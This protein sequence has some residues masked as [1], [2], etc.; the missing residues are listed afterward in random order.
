MP[1][2]YRLHPEIQW[3]QK[4]QLL[5][6]GI[7]EYLLSI[8]CKSHI[9]YTPSDRR[10]GR[11]PALK[12][13]GLVE[14][15]KVTKE[16]SMS[17]HLL[18][19]KL[20][21]LMRMKRVYSIVTS[22]R[23]NTPSGR[24]QLIDLKFALHIPPRQLHTLPHKLFR[25]AK[26]KERA[27]WGGQYTQEEWDLRH[28]VGNSL[29]SAHTLIEC[30]QRE[31]MR[32]AQHSLLV[33]PQLHPHYVSGLIEGNGYIRT[34][35]KLTQLP[36]V[37]ITMERGAELVLISV[38][39]FFH[40]LKPSCSLGES[41]TEYR[42]ARR[43]LLTRLCHHFVSFPILFKEETSLLFLKRCAFKGIS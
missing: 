23:H 37:A 17:P 34:P 39:A 35:S 43:E 4:N 22:G 30:A 25:C 41:S 27:V 9:K 32:F 15:G 11:A 21:D 16:L 3:S 12:V 19:G 36:Q 40:D 8:N 5:L 1:I 42:L 28:G 24:M 20:Y 2:R 26:I 31:Y 10:A 38:A 33:V 14:C 29:D 7:K 6:Q 18:G 13:S